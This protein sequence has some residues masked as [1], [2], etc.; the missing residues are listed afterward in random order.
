MSQK[1]RSYMTIKYKETQNKNNYHATNK[2]SFATQ[3]A[4]VFVP[5]AYLGEIAPM[6]SA[7]IAPL[8]KHMTPQIVISITFPKKIMI[9]IV[10]K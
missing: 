7:K 6:A 1:Y 4:M 5:G 9:T 2:L 3:M 8:S 10:E